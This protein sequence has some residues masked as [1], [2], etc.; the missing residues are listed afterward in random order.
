MAQTQL[1]GAAVIGGGARGADI[2]LTFA[3]GG[4]PTHV[5]ETSA[6]ARAALPRYFAQM[7]WEMGYSENEDSLSV[8]ADLESAP[9]TEIEIVV[10]CIPEELELKRRLFA[11]LEQLVDRKTILASGSSVLPISRIAAGLSTR[12]RMF[13][14]HFMTPAYLVPLVEVVR[15][16]ASDPALADQLGELVRSLGKVPVQ[17]KKDVPGFIANRLQHALAREAYALIDAGIGT[18]EDIDAAVRFGFGFR[19]LAA[20]PCLQRDHL[21]LDVDYAA[22]KTIYPE[23]ANEIEPAGILR[24][25]VQA[26][27]LGMKTGKG[28]YGWD[29]ISI[30]QEKARYHGLLAAGLE[31]LKDELPERTPE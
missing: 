15:S 10:E 8:H 4:W 11:Q 12:N 2:A 6:S 16:E 13:S 26:G 30:Q 28:F 14:L 19:S 20:G 27:H 3:A 18:V 5:I 22:A 21:G 25:R 31:L 24:E 7:L 29:E 17:V 9:W 1:R 23:L